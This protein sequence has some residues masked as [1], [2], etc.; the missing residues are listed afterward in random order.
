MRRANRRLEYGDESDPVIRAFLERI[1]PLNN[2]EKISAP[3]FIT[4]GETDT[5]VTVH[6]AVAMYKIVRG[7]LGERAQLVICEGEGHS[8]LPTAWSCSLVVAYADLNWCRVQAKERD[9]IRERC[10]DRLFEEIPAILVS[11][12][13][14]VSFFHKP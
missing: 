2:A 4:H 1:S 5:R 7:T 6:E 13:L 10:H 9:R 12:S 3:L 14:R 8:E 11:S